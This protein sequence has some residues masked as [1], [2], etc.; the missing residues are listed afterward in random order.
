MEALRPITTD[1][2]L[3][4]SSQREG[5]TASRRWAS[6]AAALVLFGAVPAGTSWA[7]QYAFTKEDCARKYNFCA[8]CDTPL[9][10]TAVK[11]SYCMFPYQAKGGLF[12]QTLTVKPRHGEYI[13]IS[14]ARGVYKPNA[15]FLG[16]DY[17]E[18]RINYGLAN[19]SR[20]HT[21]LKANVSV[22]ERRR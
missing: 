3:M 16:N 6:R 12:G 9:S 15:G 18:V 2:R 11:N 22:V 21:T 19:G 8:G 5:F 20:T 1:K 17:Y 13:I 7:Q 14:P 10:I 4:T